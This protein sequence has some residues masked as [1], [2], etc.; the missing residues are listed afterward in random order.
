MAFF[1]PLIAAMGGNAGVQASAIVVQG[2]ATKSIRY[3]RIFEKFVKEFRVSI[4]NG[5]ICGAVLLGYGI[6]FTSGLNIS[7]TISLSL[8]IVILLA[9]SFGA[10]IPLLLH[11]LKIDPALATGPFIT[12]ANDIIGLGVYFLIGRLMYN[13]PIL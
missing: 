9:S 2:L 3:N 11:R 6:M 4:L 13:L 1:I 8:L 5:L 7:F 10:L 12:T